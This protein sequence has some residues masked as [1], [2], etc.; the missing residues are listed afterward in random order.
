MVEEWA[1]QLLD[2]LALL[3]WGLPRAILSDRNRKFTATL[4]RSLF[5]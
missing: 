3:N 2:R 5:R 4:W 1:I